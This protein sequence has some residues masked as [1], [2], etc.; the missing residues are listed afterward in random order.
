[1]PKVAY[2]RLLLACRH[3]DSKYRLL[4]NGVLETDD[5]GVQ[6][7]RILCDPDKAKAILNLARDTSPDILAAIQEIQNLPDEFPSD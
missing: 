5:N 6:Q 3:D 1:V 4:R 7:V 2:E